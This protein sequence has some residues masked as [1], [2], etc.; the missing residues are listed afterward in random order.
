M[1]E[2]VRCGVAVCVAAAATA[3][4][5]ADRCSPVVSVAVYSLS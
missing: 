1:S 5:A 2:I 4:A 3:T